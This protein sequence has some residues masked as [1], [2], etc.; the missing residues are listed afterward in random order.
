M[1]LKVFLGAEQW[2]ATFRGIVPFSPVPS[3]PSFS[4]SGRVIAIHLDAG[5]S[6]VLR[7]VWNYKPTET[8]QHPSNTFVLSPGLERKQQVTVQLLSVYSRA[9]CWAALNRDAEDHAKFFF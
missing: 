2:L 8:A 6:T 3:R 7:S 1:R 5:L 9:I 4:G